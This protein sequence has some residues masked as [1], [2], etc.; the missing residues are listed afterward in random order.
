MALPTSRNTTYGTGTPISP[1]DLNMMQD[2]IIGAKHGLIPLTINAA[3]FRPIT[4]SAAAVSFLLGRWEFSSGGTLIAPVSLPAGSAVQQLTWQLN[5]NSKAT[6]LSCAFRAV[7]L[8]IN[9]FGE[10]FFSEDV[11]TGG[12]FH[13]FVQTFTRTLLPDVSYYLTLSAT[14]DV[15]GMALEGVTVRYSRN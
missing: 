6:A 1:N 2:C 10:E 12:T 14:G 8:G 9:L 3:A 11:T 5:K 7:Q 4:T 13:N 15:A